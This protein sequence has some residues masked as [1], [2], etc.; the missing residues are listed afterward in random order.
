MDTALTRQKLLKAALVVALLI[1]VAASLGA[2]YTAARDRWL[3][4]NP[5]NALDHPAVP[6]P[7]GLAGKTVFLGTD[8]GVVALAAASGA[9]RWSYPT[10]Q[11]VASGS[12]HIGASPRVTS[13]A[14]CAST[15]YVALVNG[16]VVALRASDGAP[17][18]S[19]TVVSQ[20]VMPTV[21]C[22]DGVV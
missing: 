14:L 7:A 9:M 8:G 17:L 11:Q 12:Q 10:A 3:M 5:I 22:A 15:L 4:S 20:S 1:G 16:P 2:V 13:M 6:A 21:T 19:S 18:W